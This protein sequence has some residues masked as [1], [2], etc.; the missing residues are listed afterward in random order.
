M[1]ARA[2]ATIDGLAAGAASPNEL[3]LAIRRLL[4]EVARDGPLVVVFDDIHWGEPTFLDLLDHIAD[5]SRGAPI[6]LLCLAR[7]EL[8]DERPAWGGGKLNATTLLL[9]PL[10]PT[11]ARALI[12]ELDGDV[13][14]ATR[15]R[16]I[17]TADGNPLFA[18]EML[19]FAREGGDIAVPSTIQALLQARLD[20]LGADERAVIERGAVEGQVFHSS[21]VRELGPEAARSG[22]DQS[23]V[24]LVRKELIRPD[25]PMFA[26]DDAFRFR[27]LLIRDA[28]YESLPKETRADLHARFGDWIE[29]RRELV[30]LDE[31]AGYHQE[32]A[33]LYLRELGRDDPELAARAGMHLG[34]AGT[35]ALGRS[36]FHAACNLLERALVLLPAV[37]ERDA[38]G[39]TLAEACMHAGRYDLM[40]ELLGPLTRSTEPLI[41]AQARILEAHARI[42]ADPHG[43]AAQ[44]RTV[45]DELLPQLEGRRDDGALARAWLLE[46]MLAW[47]S[48]RAE[49]AARASRLALAHA[50]RAGDQRLHGVAAY[51][52]AAAAAWGPAPP[53]EQEALIREL[54]TEHGDSPAAR[55]GAEYVRTTYLMNRGE[56]DAAREASERLLAAHLELGEEVLAA[57]DLGRSAPSSS[58]GTARPPKPFGS[59]RARAVACSSLAR[60]RGD[61]R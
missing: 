14:A 43:A 17:E 28:A 34:R 53:A 18:E 54:E 20:R 51:T 38:A 37:V 1:A 33:V 15:A 16:I 4:E 8:L 12:E 23:L 22:V 57:A 47:L 55:T 48:S 44:A 6:L 41:A 24:G 3:F 32:Q 50:R 25:E 35:S 11:S 60:R 52:L 9:E 42:Q 19:E 45:L 7:P 36:D 61:Q 21:A 5:L 2:D 27:H 49:P 46:S 39:F 13:D 58:A 26:G 29:G 56:L 31:I 40:F 59:S 30:E 10:R